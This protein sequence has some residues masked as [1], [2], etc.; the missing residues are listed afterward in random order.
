MLSDLIIEWVAI[1][2][3]PFGLWDLVDWAF[4]LGILSLGGTLLAFLLVLKDVVFIYRRKNRLRHLKRRWDVCFLV[5][6][7]NLPAIPKKIGP[8]DFSLFA[9]LWLSH[10]KSAPDIRRQPLEELA[11]YSGLR[12]LSLLQL[13]RASVN[14]SLAL[15]IDVLGLLNE[16]EFFMQI[17]PFLTQK[18]TGISFIAARALSRMDP[19]KAAPMILERIISNPEWPSNHVGRMFSVMG[20]AA[21]TDPY[22]DLLPS[23]IPSQDDA[24]LAQYLRYIDR[25]KL[26]EIVQLTKSSRF[27][28]LWEAS[29]LALMEDP[30]EFQFVI[31]RMNSSDPGVRCAAIKA[32]SR[33][34][35][36]SEAGFLGSLLD[37]EA[38]RV[39]TLAA[40]TL[41]S[42]FKHDW[43]AIDHF[44]AITPIN[45]H[46]TA[47]LLELR[48][49][50]VLAS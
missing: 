45:V 14:H 16:K 36:A 34:A 32:F 40:E 29:C 8:R 26:E 3:A 46:G 22:L 4:F 10:Y 42:I 35:P 37:D 25:K 20:T 27:L 19:F 5:T 30:K 9:E 13:R 50:D 31:S 11:R 15:A 39:R 6:R 2:R 49:D 24:P 1:N 18:N 44:M 38:W 33:L 23:I 47:L 21:L 28:H 43:V 41:I 17:L 48:P 7:E 12:E